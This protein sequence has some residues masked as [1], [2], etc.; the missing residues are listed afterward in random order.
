MKIRNFDSQDIY[1]KNLLP[2]LVHSVKD[3]QRPSLRGYIIT[4]WI[5]IFM[6]LSSQAFAFTQYSAGTMPMGHEWITRLAWY[7]LFG[8]RQKLNGDPVC[9][10]QEGDPRNDIEKSRIQMAQ[11]LT[12][13]TDARWFYEADT[14][15]KD[16]RGKAY[17]Y[18][19]MSFDKWYERYGV[20]NLA[21][22]SAIMGVRWVDI[23]GF[24]ILQA[25]GIKELYSLE[26]DPWSAVAQETGGVQCHHYMRKWDEV[27][28]KGG[29]SAAKSSCA[30]FKEFFVN[31]VLAENA[32]VTVLDGGG[33][34]EKVNVDHGFFLLGRALHVFQDAFSSEHTVRS[35]LDN[36]RTVRQVKSYLCAPG[37]EQHDHE[38]VNIVGF[39]SGDVVW[40]R[41]SYKNF[42]EVGWRSYRAFNMK[43]LALV[44]TEGTKDV[45]AAYLRS[46]LQARL[47]SKHYLRKWAEAEADILIQ[48]WLS[49][50]AGRMEEWYKHN[51]RNKTYVKEY[52]GD[53]GQD[54]QTCL[55]NIGAEVKNKSREKRNSELVK[56]RR[57][58]L[59]NMKATP[60]YDYDPL[61]DPYLKVP[62]VW[63]WP[64]VLD[65]NLPEGY[66]PDAHR[67]P[68]YWPHKLV[69]IKKPGSQNFLTLKNQDGEYETKFGLAN[70]V[71]NHDGWGRSITFEMV[72]DPKQWCYFRVAGD[73]RYFL[74][75]WGD[76]SDGATALFDRV[77]NILGNI[78][79]SFKLEYWDK[80]TGKAAIYNNHHKQYMSRGTTIFF[81]ET[82]VAVDRSK[83]AGDAAAKWIIEPAPL[84][85]HWEK[86]GKSL[87]FISVANDGTVW[88]IDPQGNTFRYVKKSGGLSTEWQQ[89][90]GKKVQLS[91]GSHD[92]VWS[93]NAAG[94]IFRW[95][96]GESTSK[97]GWKQ[98]PGNNMKWVSV[99]EDGAVWAVNKD[100]AVYR[101]SGGGWDWLQKC[102]FKQISV[103]NKD[104]IWG[105]NKDNQI[106]RWYGDVSTTENKWTHVPD[107]MKNIT[108]GADEVVYGINEAGT[109]C[110]RQGD[111]WVI[112]ENTSGTIFSAGNMHRKWHVNGDN[113]VYYWVL[114]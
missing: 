73:P 39:L 105:V 9:K 47:L 98:M 48:N 77:T 63:Q 65:L 88:G 42:A 30:A 51:Y 16:W 56:A 33:S 41:A 103:G 114:N 97:S 14:W 83:S 102:D 84:P 76:V 90:G 53:S 107:K 66:N 18:T 111:Y 1:K 69:K 45:F 96:G 112:L 46:R 12:M 61:T 44:A 24:N 62:Y 50:D 71:E 101:W 67:E 70:N 28:G 78:D 57:I 49:Y 35:D 80:E 85:G 40:T 59:F 23:S 99:A 32:L 113:E 58:S 87:S 108:V 104:E 89:I 37:S 82:F 81:P 20:D 13:P 27:G 54:C 29:V 75:N 19:G 68:K 74:G 64:S 11:N 100:D 4:I 15:K 17:R 72:G 43:P 86:M 52:D 6:G 5:C 94:K 31:A 92:K 21:V 38:L 36:Y 10:A 2:R 25:K 91:C 110:R 26:A 109:L 93:I 95:E 106:Y 8:T 79:G 7:E 34:T 3:S 55:N 60:G 22:Y